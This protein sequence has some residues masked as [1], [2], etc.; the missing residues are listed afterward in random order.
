MHSGVGLSSQ[1]VKSE[2]GRLL[3]PC[4]PSLAWAQKAWGTEG[5]KG[6]GAGEMA[7]LIMSLVFKHKDLSSVS[8]QTL[9]KLAMAASVYNP[10]RGCG[11]RSWWLAGQLAQP[12]SKS[13]GSVSQ[14][15]RQRATEE[16]IQW[17][18]L[19]SMYICT[20][21]YLHPHMP[22]TYMNICTHIQTKKTKEKPKKI[23]NRIEQKFTE[24]LLCEV[25]ANQLTG[26]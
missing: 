3:E 11:D 18:P 24:Y 20:H 17:H 8:W 16:D 7:Q 10:H 19:A 21:V 1:Q 4:T 9:N 15:G 22:C 23:N 14:K 26:R 13:P 5:R 12:E 6:E 25:L 2:A